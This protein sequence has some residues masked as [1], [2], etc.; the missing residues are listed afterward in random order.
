MNDEEEAQVSEL[1]ETE[2]SSSLALLIEYKLVS[3]LLEEAWFGRGILIDVMRSSVDA[4]GYD[5]VFESGSVIRH[6]QLKTRK[7]QGRNAAYG[8][9]TKLAERPSGCVIWMG[10]ERKPGTNELA[11]TYKFLGGP[12]G[13][14]L[15]PLGDAPVKH[16]KA[17]KDGVKAVRPGLRKVNLSSFKPVKDI[18]ELLDK[19]FGPLQA[20][21]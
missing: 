9:N 18:P 12:P 1:S 6:V 17:N 8:I 21:R 11:L 19:L 10:Y 20:D 14:P 16:A 15:P 2:H 5:I 4:F 7:K 3:A 13:E